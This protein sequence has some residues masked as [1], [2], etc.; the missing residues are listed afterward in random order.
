MVLPKKTRQTGSRPNE[1]K[2][3]GERSRVTEHRR[4]EKKT[5]IFVHLHAKQTERETQ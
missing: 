5:M 2:G 3:A 1:V 4:R